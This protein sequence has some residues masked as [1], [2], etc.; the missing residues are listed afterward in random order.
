V[1]RLTVARL[2]ARSTVVHHEPWEGQYATALRAADP[3]VGD[4][5]PGTRAIRSKRGGWARALS[6]GGIRTDWRHAQPP[7]PQGPLGGLV[8]Q[9][10]IEEILLQLLSRDA[11]M[12][13]Q[14]NGRGARH[15]PELAIHFET[16]D[17][18]AV[19]PN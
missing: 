12:M 4:D 13:G 2:S 11:E 15:H 6:Y 14:G 1:A 7:E 3:G 19:R 10:L 17:K 9:G 16:V 5:V 18:A 8:K